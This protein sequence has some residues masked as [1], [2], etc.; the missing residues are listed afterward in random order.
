MLSRKEV[1]QNSAAR[2]FR[3]K[4]FKSTSMDNIAEAVGIKAASIYNHID[5]KQELLSELLI[6]IAQRFTQGMEEI[7]SSSLGIEKKLE[8]VIALHIRLAVEQTDSVALITGEWVHLEE[9]AK[10]KYLALRDN[11]EDQFRSIIETGKEEGFYKNLDTEI[12]LFSI[13]SSLRWLYSWYS[14]NKAYNQ[15]DLEQQLTQ[16][17]IEGIKR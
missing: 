13:L 10:S 9:K 3:K 6:G 14:K 4:G 7:Q 17:L 5:S 11:Y 2:L 12:I 15:I 1:I 16:C 8:R